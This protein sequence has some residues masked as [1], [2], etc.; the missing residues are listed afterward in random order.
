MSITIKI[1]ERIR[2]ARKKKGITSKSM[3]E[4]VNMSTQVVS[5]W[6]NGRRVPTLD[7]IIALSEILEVPAG[8]LLCIDE[9]QSKPKL[10]K[11]PLHDTDSFF[12]KSALNELVV[13]TTMINDTTGL[14]AIKL[15]DNSMEPLFRKGD[16]IIINTKKSLYDRALVLIQINKTKQVLLR[17]CIINNSD[18]KSPCISFNPYNDTYESISHDPSAIS[19][20]GISEDNTRL[21]F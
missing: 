7:A 2:T 12:E 13:P 17:K 6:E 1:G 5:H 18:A 21:S 3:A 19:I 20:L 10:K 11:I 16:I 9:D 14:I 4:A 8:Y 15:T